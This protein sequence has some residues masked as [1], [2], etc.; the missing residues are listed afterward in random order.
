MALFVFIDITCIVD[1]VAISGD[2]YDSSSSFIARVHEI[3]WYESFNST[4]LNS[5]SSFFMS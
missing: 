5:Q 2:T 4:I 3:D 1:L